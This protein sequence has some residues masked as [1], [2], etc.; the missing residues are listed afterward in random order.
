[1]R[2]PILI[3]LLALLVRLAYAW[4][5]RNTPLAEILLID[6][7]TY[8]RL[9]RLILDG[10]FHGETVYSMNV[11]YPYF[12]AGVYTLL[13]DGVLPVLVVQ[14][15]LDSVTCLLLIWIG[16]RLM[17]RAPALIAGLGYALYGPAVFYTGT[18]LTPTL[19]NLLA[20]GALALLVRYRSRPQV[21]SATLAGVVLGL[22]A[23]GR[24][25]AMLM[26]PLAT[27]LFLL[28]VPRRRAV[29]HWL[30]FAVGAA[31]VTGAVTLRN[32]LVE[33]ELV[34]V[35]ANYAAFYIG[36]N[37]D[38]NGLYTM[39]SFTSGA[40]FEDEVWG[41][42]EAI[43]AKV[44]RELS[45]AET[46]QYLFQEGMRY[47][48]DH[49]VEDFKLAA[50]KFYFFWN[51]T[52]SP[53]NL[54]YYFARDFSPVLRMVPL[55]MGILAPLGLLGM[56]LARKRWRELLVLYLYAVIF[57]LTGVLFFVSAE[58]RLPIVPVLLL[59][60]GDA[61]VR[62][63]GAL[64]GSRSGKRATEHPSRR[65]VLITSAVLLPALLVACHVRTPLLA[66]QSLKRVDYLNFG[67]LYRL[68]G[69]LDRSR[70]MLQRSLAIDPRYARAYSSLAETERLAGNTQRAA[71]LLAEASRYGES[72]SAVQDPMAQDM[73]SAG[74]LY[75]EGEYTEALL[76][77]QALLRTAVQ[78]G[79][80][81]QARQIQN[82]IGL[83]R[84]KLGNLEAA[85]E[86]F[87]GILQKDPTYVKAYN[88]L[89]LVREK[90]FQ[91]EEAL[92]LFR[93]TLARD[94]AN[95]VAGK[96]VYRLTGPGG[97]LEG[98]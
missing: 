79:N 55:G 95:V 78:S 21:V 27:P 3:S 94:P 8:D 92:A 87:S 10:Q 70:D 6:S 64:R 65:A 34:P 62:L 33:K 25:N 86:I 60:A 48:R 83:C 32:F 54:N 68:R 41:T 85:S 23:L 89:A 47:V 75:R 81:D 80:Q 53:T 35:A 19:I 24:G 26:V 97:V 7:E 2:H 74:M 43:S 51:R 30:A 96:G 44:G 17:G 49:P 88:N 98:S 20:M 29:V 16:L 56:I 36:H 61:G 12:L 18:L 76:A 45:L 38:A 9:A 63:W 4:S 93:E 77:F 13:G 46:S 50:R 73:L 40:A 5:I 84:Y 42:R 39:P 69:D 15:V 59:F 66:A 57:P 11:L 28:A 52:E 71:Q 91:F 1:M 58:Y 22:C 90:Q 37:A 82:N 72:G 31:A 67:T 14:A